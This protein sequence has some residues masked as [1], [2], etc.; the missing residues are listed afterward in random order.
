[1]V[2]NPVTWI[3]ILTNTTGSGSNQVT[4]SVEANS[5][6]PFER[7]ATLTV[8]G[9]SL[10]ITQRGITCNYSL[11]PKSV[12]HGNGLATNTFTLTTTNGCAWTVTNDHPW[13]TITSNATGTATATVGYTV[14]QNP[15]A[16]TRIGTLYVDGQTFI[17]T[18]LA[19][20]CS[21]TLSPKSVSHG[22]GATSDSFNVTTPGG[23]PWTLTNDHP[24]IT[25]L[26]NATGSATATVGYTIEETPPPPNA[27]PPF[28]SMAKPLPSPR[29]P[30]PAPS[31]S[32]PPTATT[33]TAP[34]TTPSKS[35]PPPDAVGKPPPPTPG[36]RSPPANWAPALAPSATP[37]PRT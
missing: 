12:T 21:Y 22:Y 20:A 37:S 31:P 15:T 29:K 28:S 5:L 2:E 13:I 17:I 23:C 18:Q 35:T 36:S 16:F 24:W 8:A 7:I 9:Q 27:S 19:T 6:T 33:A 10:V 4:Y 11:S 14:E 25:I 26:S 3:N 34:P 1:M 32:P 30:P